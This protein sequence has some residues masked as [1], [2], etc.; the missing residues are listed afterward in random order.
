MSLAEWQH[1]ASFSTISVTALA[2]NI[3]S[4]GFTRHAPE[5]MN[6]SQ[7]KH[8]FGSAN[9]LHDSAQSQPTFFDSTQDTHGSSEFASETRP[10]CKSHCCI[11]P[12]LFRSC[13]IRH[14]VTHCHEHDALR[15]RSSGAQRTTTTSR[16]R[17][18]WMLEICSRQELK[19]IQFASVADHGRPASE[20]LAS[21]LRAGS[22]T[23]LSSCTSPNPSRTCGCTWLHPSSRDAR[24]VWQ[25]TERKNM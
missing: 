24:G 8:H 7:L 21:R 17:V 23:E 13:G 15:T 6:N 3:E 16:E 18:D 11:H 10:V 5:C 25:S 14:R 4:I 9:P 22:S 20:Q 1:N 12:W 19:R 2:V